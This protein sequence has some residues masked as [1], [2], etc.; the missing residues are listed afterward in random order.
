MNPI[1][2]VLIET[3]HG[4][5][6]VIGLAAFPYALLAA[7]LWTL[8]AWPGEII[9]FIGG[10]FLPV[11]A[12]IGLI[13]A[14]LVASLGFLGSWGAYAL[15]DLGSVASP[16]V[17]CANVNSYARTFLAGLLAYAVGLALR[18]AWMSRAGILLPAKH[19]Q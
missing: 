15:N 7:L 13:V 4:H 8:T 10:A 11:R 17:N 2:C 3:V 1:P 14:A 9:W 12:K 16:P 6:A 18:R 5:M 19:T